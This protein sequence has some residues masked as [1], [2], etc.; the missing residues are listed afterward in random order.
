[1]R[2]LTVSKIANILG[3]EKSIIENTLSRGDEELSLYV[4]QEKNNQ[5]NVEYIL[6]LEGLPLLIK[7]LSINLP[8]TEIIEN[9]ACQ[10][11]HL[12]ALEYNNVSLKEELE[13]VREEVEKLRQEVANLENRIE[14]ERNKSLKHKI[15][16]IFGY[17]EEKDK[18]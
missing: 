16:K 4:S 5:Q 11:L 9:L 12:T 1:M 13:V 18:E 2:K 10:V 6:D 3:F 17:N 14:E 7:K 8:T 15:G